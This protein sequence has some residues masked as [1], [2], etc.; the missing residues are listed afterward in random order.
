MI[1]CRAGL[2]FVFVHYFATSIAVGSDLTVARYDTSDSAL[3]HTSCLF[4][5]VLEEFS[6]Q[7]TIEHIL[8]R[9]PKTKEA[10][11]QAKAQAA[12]VE[13]SR[14]AYFPKLNASSNTSL[15]HNVTDYD[16]HTELSSRGNQRQ[17]SNNLHLSWLLYD[18][19]RREA[20]TLAAKQLLVAANAN[21][22]VVIQNAFISAAY[23]Y[24]SA[25]AAQHNVVTSA[26]VAVLASENRIAAEARYRAGTAALSDWL[27]AQTAYTQASLNEVRDAGVLR[28]ATGAI[29]LRIGLSPDTTINLAGNLTPS[30]DAHYSIDELIHEAQK[31]HPALLAARAS[32]KAAEAKLEESRAAGKP[33]LSLTADL[34]HSR[35][36]PSQITN[37]NRRERDRAVGLQLNVPLFEGFGRKYQIRNDLSRLEAAKAKLLD[38][39]QELSLALWDTFQV[40]SIETQRMKRTA[41]LVAQSR[42][43]LE[44]AQGRYRSGVGSMVELLS[45]L[46]AYAGAEEQHTNTLS[47]WQIARLKVGTHLGRL[48]FWNINS[49][50]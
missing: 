35:I 34:T 22:D 24:Y 12:L 36:E 6:L 2:F 31:S 15:G 4:K 19:G 45:A 37:G 25:L 29:A 28:K 10:W 7:E 38:E 14:S 20:R 23:L 27:Q 11:A 9:D 21:Q 17:V 40:L 16:K 33:T 26:K 44:V 43:S 13:V 46:A 1:Y 49:L 47:S 39:E 18:F 30:A 48:D 41:Q 8:C 3:L 32:I 5:G 42:Q 50:Q